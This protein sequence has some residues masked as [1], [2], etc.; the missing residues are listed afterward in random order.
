M[1]LYL[2]EKFENWLKARDKRI[3][4]IIFIFSLIIAFIASIGIS[5]AENTLQYAM[6][7]TI[8]LL[9]IY[10][11]ILVLQNLDESNSHNKPS[12]RKSIL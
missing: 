4:E 8:A 10:S 2:K 5:N 11:A 12:Q 1:R 6:S 7:A 9:S 3:K